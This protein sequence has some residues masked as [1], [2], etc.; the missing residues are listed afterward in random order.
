M[1]FGAGTGGVRAAST[2][3]VVGVDEA[4]L[5]PSVFGAMPPSDI[6]EEMLEIN[7]FDLLRSLERQA[8]QLQ[9]EAEE[10]SAVLAQTKASGSGSSSSS[11][12]GSG[13]GSNASSVRS[14]ASMSVSV[15]NLCVST[16]E[17]EREPTPAAFLE[18][19]ASVARRQFNIFIHS[20]S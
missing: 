6:T 10:D 20:L 14:T 1:T 4:V 5:E 18:S 8:S 19:F 12:S 15:P 16:S 11:G 7:A 3:E 2:P 13:S 17:P 9:A